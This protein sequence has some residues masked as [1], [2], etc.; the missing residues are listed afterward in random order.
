MLKILA[1]SRVMQNCGP[2]TRSQ[3]GNDA[4]GLTFDDFLKKSARRHC[5]RDLLDIR[6]TIE[7]RHLKEEQCTWNGHR[8]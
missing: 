1:D 8:L 2:S 7:I 4:I 5:E 6:R 3:F